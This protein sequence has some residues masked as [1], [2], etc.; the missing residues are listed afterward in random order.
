V[1]RPA[2]SHW[3]TDQIVTNTSD[4][5]ILTNLNQIWVILRQAPICEGRILHHFEAMGI[6]LLSVE[7]R[8]LFDGLRP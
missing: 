7:P 6:F 3:A 8:R 1:I 2:V 4:V 5:G